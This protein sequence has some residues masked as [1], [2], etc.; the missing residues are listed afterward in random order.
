MDPYSTLG[1]GRTASDSE[2][3]SAYRRL[4]MKHHPDKGGDSQKFAQI[5][6][7][8][9]VLKDPQRR[10]EYD[11]PQPQFN[12]FNNVPPGFEDIFANAF[13]AG[14]RQQQYQRPVRN[15]N[16]TI[17]HTLTLE[18]VYTGK[19][20]FANYSLSN[21]RIEKLEMNIPPGVDHNSTV[22][23]RGYGDDVIP[24]VPRGDLILKVRVRKHP[25]WVK[26]GLNIMKNQKVD[27]I[28]CILGTEVQID[29]PNQKS[30]VLKIPA[31]TK[32]G[33]TFSI[34][35][36]GIPNRNTGKTGNVYVS[37]EA[38]IP[39]LKSNKLIKEL[40]AFKDKMAR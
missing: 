28:D 12:G 30:V 40:R 32:T 2:I 38:D 3:K 7:A 24:N 16:I 1:V 5:N 37:I 35:G 33:T 26:D 29:M 11:N 19:T 8:Y 31:G 9:E 20:V 6:E 34:G 14:F 4:A 18:E 23:F 13:G 27:A 21:G 15:K 17:G 36:Y 22:V 25:I 39:K 10:A